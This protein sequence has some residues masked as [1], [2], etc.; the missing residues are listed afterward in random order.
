MGQG[1]WG[2]SGITT[3]PIRLWSQ[4]NY[5]EDLVFAY[6]GG[7]LCYWA[8]NTGVTVRG[9]VIDTVNYPTSTDVPS[10]VNF[11]TVSDIY[12]FVFCFGANT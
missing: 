12:R 8:A 11:V 1:T 6:R 2:N 9:K 10:I 4:S 3:S 5:G 7:P